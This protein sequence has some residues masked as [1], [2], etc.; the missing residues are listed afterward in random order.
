MKKVFE[1][2][3]VIKDKLMRKITYI[4]ELLHFFGILVDYE[5][6]SL[7]TTE[8]GEDILITVHFPIYPEFWLNL[9]SF[10]TLLYFHSP[11][12]SNRSVGGMIAELED[13]DFQVIEG[14]YLRV[15]NTYKKVAT[16]LFTNLR[17]Y[18]PAFSISS[19]KFI[20]KNCTL[21]NRTDLRFIAGV[22]VK[23]M[24]YNRGSFLKYFYNKN[25][26]MTLDNDRVIGEID[27][28]HQKVF[29]LNPTWVLSWDEKDIVMSP[30]FWVILLGIMNGDFEGVKDL[31]SF[32]EKFQGG[33]IVYKR[34]K[35]TKKVLR[36]QETGKETTNSDF[37]TTNKIKRKN[38]WI[39]HY[40]SC[41]EVK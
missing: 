10:R 12:N 11:V 8:N 23:Y 2:N 21:N 32:R 22:I 1:D 30:S 20:I 39:V 35:E 31:K 24:S 5:N 19:L 41:S 17:S 26:R 29:L 13:N 40:K 3:R 16:N 28:F 9:L 36:D 7:L 34:G 27:L 37:M 6:V 15:I 25:L 14:T 38:S 4:R 18:S 33:S